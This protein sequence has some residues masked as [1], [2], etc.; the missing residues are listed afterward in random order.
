MYLASLLVAKAAQ[1]HE[2]GIQLHIAAEGVVRPDTFQATDIVTIVGNLLDNAMDVSVGTEEAT[3]WVEVTALD[4]AVMISVADSGPGIE[5]E[6]IE[7]LMRFGVSTKNGTQP[8]GLGL[9]LVQQAVT[10]LHGTMSVDNDAGAI[11]TVTLP[12]AGP[13]GV[14]NSSGEV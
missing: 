13:A 12:V 7:N 11:F 1:A 10:R 5:P 4:D 9:A 6:F 2:R 3:V 8:R 14:E